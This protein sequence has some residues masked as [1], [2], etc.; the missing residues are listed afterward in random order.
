MRARLQP[1]NAPAEAAATVRRHVAPLP[2]RLTLAAALAGG[3][4]NSAIQRLVGADSARQVNAA[5]AFDLAT[6]GTPGPVP[7]R[8]RM[9]ADFGRDFG[10]VSAYAGGA[11]ARSGL[12]ALG[13]VAA[14]YGN[15]VAFADASPAPEVVAHE[16]T[17]VVQHEGVSLPARPAGVSSPVDAAERAATAKAPALIHRL[18]KTTGGTWSTPTYS[19][20]NRGNGVGKTIGADIIL[21]F[22]ANDLV[23]AAQI[24]LSQSVRTLKSTTPRGEAD[25]PSNARTIPDYLRPDIGMVD[26]GRGIDRVDYAAGGTL[27][28]TNPL[29]GV[30]NTPAA[31][32]APA[33]VSQALGDV[34]ASARTN[35][36]GAHT[37]RPNGTFN[38]AVDAVL[39]DEPKR[40]LGFAGERWQQKFEVTALAISGPLAG[41]YLGSIAWGWHTDDHDTARLDPGQ[42]AVVRE[43]PP[44]DAFIDAAYKWN[45]MTLTDPTTGVNYNTVDLPMDH[46]VA[47][48]STD[49]LAE[50]LVDLRR[51]A[52]ALPAADPAKAHR[53]FQSI[54]YEQE[55]GRRAIEVSVHV[56]KTEDRTTDNVYAKIIGQKKHRTAVTNMKAGEDHDF[57]IPLDTIA[58]A[59]PLAPTPLQVEV[60]DEDWIDPDDR[61]VAMTW[62]PGK[63][64]AQNKGSMDGADYAVRVSWA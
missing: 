18:V 39:D 16:L 29:Y 11:G 55:L 45:T 14:T 43:G 56:R 19:A 31:G 30:H 53:K 7:H 48:F 9:E 17:H 47:L 36:T 59:L 38:P 25:T 6:S 49:D 4:G 24:G 61:I 10:D 15:R 23:E 35:A 54:V 34:P 62:T 21:H 64:V 33:V 37:R 57:L 63:G 46:D 50:R 22:T 12:D 60:F 32:A 28:T 8:R 42:I 13:A 27:P 2:N 52:A 1:E 41:T 26:V 40:T 58:T 3:A 5:D 51:E 20:L 44:S